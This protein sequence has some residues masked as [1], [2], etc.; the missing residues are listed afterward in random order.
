MNNRIL[1]AITAIITAINFCGCASSA[2]AEKP[3]SNSSEGSDESSIQTTVTEAQTEVTQ[4]PLPPAALSLFIC[5]S[6]EIGFD[7]PVAKKI[8]ELTGVTLDI[9]CSSGDGSDD[10]RSMASAG[11]LPDLIYAGDYTQTL[12]DAGALVPLDKYIAA[13]GHN[14]TKMYASQLTRLKNSSDDKIYTFG[15]GGI[16]SSSF[17]VNGTFQIQN[18]VLKDQNYPEIKT[19]EQFEN[20]IKAYAEKYPEINGLTT[21]GLALCGGTRDFWLNTIGRA[22]LAL[23]YPDDEDFI[24]DDTKGTASY[25]WLNDGFRGYYKWLN[26]LYNEGLVDKDTLRKKHTDYVEALKGGNIIAV[27]DNFEDYAEADEYLRENEMTDR[28]YVPLPVTADKDILQAELTDYGYSGEFGIGITVNCGNPERAF[29]FLDMW[30]SDEIQTLVSWGI[31]GENYK[32]GAD[33]KRAFTADEL[34]KQKSETYKTD[35]GVGLYLRPF[36][37]Y[38][39]GIKDATGNYYSAFTPNYSADE[40]E[41]LKGYGIS[42]FTELFPSRDNF[43][44]AKHHKLSE[45][46]IPI[47][48]EAGI[49]SQSLET[50]VRAEV[51][52]AI[53]CPTDEFDAKWD[54]ITEWL[55]QNGAGNLEE[56]VSKMV[57]DDINSR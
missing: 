56:L 35:S 1:P 24:V 29:Q 31:E 37:M 16:S 20:C 25:K 45:Y 21:Q 4:A 34:E 8:T 54:E 17:C 6:D 15:T 28:T 43:P 48:S 3:N 30:C 26:G 57:R 40:K 18:A 36:P 38:G 52:N 55:E 51:L 12:I 41:T 14:F 10:I 49:L 46:N 22:E 39:D 11:T 9:T 5:N 50:Y 7:N 33:G 27:A 44:V 53:E 47:D 13:D 19:L 23:G 2:N 42:D 32:I